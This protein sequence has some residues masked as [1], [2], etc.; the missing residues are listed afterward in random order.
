MEIVKAKKRKKILTAHGHKRTD[1]YYW[2][3]DRNNP[4]VIEYLKRENR[5][6]AKVFNEPTK[7]LQKPTPTKKPQINKQNHKQNS[8]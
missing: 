7:K 5:Y 8:K 2:L 3:K 4:E 6:T 1:Y